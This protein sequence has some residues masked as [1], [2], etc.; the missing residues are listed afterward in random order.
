MRVSLGLDNNKKPEER[1]AMKKPINP[2]ENR[3]SATSPGHNGSA[4]QTAKEKALL[5]T[6]F[7]E[8]EQR[9][10]QI[11]SRNLYD[12]I[13][14]SLAVLKLSIYRFEKSLI[15]EIEAASAETQAST[16]HIIEQIRLISDALL[17]STLDDFGLLRTL[18]NLFHKHTESTGIKVHF[19]NEGLEQRMPLVTEAAI[20]RICRDTLQYVTSKAETSQLRVSARV[21]NNAVSLNISATGSG[22]D[23]PGD[24]GV[25]NTLREMASLLGGNLK[26]EALPERLRLSSR[27]PVAGSYN[28]RL[29]SSADQLLQKPED[30]VRN[31]LKRRRE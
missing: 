12:A 4:R 24:D 17:P 6:K 11:I 9:N 21:R 7:L 20:Y 14:Q 5:S 1:R 13:G 23:T 18:E 2:K 29:I 16:D 15:N 8:T 30:Q 28:G 31:Q 27:I 22:F 26:I 19:H 3:D 10:R 25:Q